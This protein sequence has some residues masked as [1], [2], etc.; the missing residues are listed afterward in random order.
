MKKI[1][2]LELDVYQNSK[3]VFD[4]VGPITKS[5]QVKS[6]I[7]ID[8]QIPVSFP[9]SFTAEFTYTKKIHDVMLDNYNICL[10]YTSVGFVCSLLLVDNS[11]NIALTHDEVLCAVELKLCTRTVS[12]TH[13]TDNHQIL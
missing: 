10:L 2:N 12:Y 7:A 13:L 9:L 11:E 1:N 5:K 6:S 8:G 4:M 3:P